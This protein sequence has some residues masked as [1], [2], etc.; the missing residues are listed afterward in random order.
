MPSA[1]SKRPPKARPSTIVYEIGAY[2]GTLLEVTNAG[3]QHVDIGYASLTAPDIVRAEVWINDRLHDVV[4]AGGGGSHSWWT[5]AGGKLLDHNGL[6]PGETLKI[7]TDGACA[8]RV[9]W[10]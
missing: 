5:Q 3:K 8:L 7:I 1:I 6:S 4:Y 10:V 2:G 9:D